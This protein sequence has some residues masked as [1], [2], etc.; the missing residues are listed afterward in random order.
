MPQYASNVTIVFGT[1]LVSLA[2]G[3]R[4]VSNAIDNTSNQY[5]QVDVEVKM[6]MGS[7]GV[8]SSGIVIIGYFGST[9]GVTY[10]NILQ[11]ESILESVTYLTNSKD[12]IVRSRLTNVPAFWKLV[13]EN[14]SGAAFDSTGANFDSFYAGIYD[15]GAPDI[16]LTTQLLIIGVPTLM[17]IPNILRE[18]LIV[19][20]LGVTP[21]FLGLPFVTTASGYPLMPGATIELPNFSDNPLFGITAGPPEPAAVMEY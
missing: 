18:N 5:G 2:N 6:R 10:E 13:V 16:F 1:P 9:D 21:I 17:A 14:T 11:G 19:Q 15:D 8:L 3:V 4:T 7:T 20:N 12:V